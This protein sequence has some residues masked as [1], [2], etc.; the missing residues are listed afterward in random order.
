MSVHSSL[1]LSEVFDD[2]AKQSTAVILSQLNWLIDRGL[3][4]VRKGSPRLVQEYDTSTVKLA[5]DLE[6]TVKD[7]EYIEKL[8][9]T[10]ES[11]KKTL[12]ELTK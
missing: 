1:H 9:Q 11:L 6:I 3:L 2:I 4:E 7:K 8:E 5:W 12:N 10:I